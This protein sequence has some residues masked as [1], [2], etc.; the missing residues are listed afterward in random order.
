M[1]EYIAAGW[2]NDGSL[3]P[4][5]E[6]LVDDATGQH[7]FVDHTTQTTSWVDPRDIFIK[8]QSF[9]DCVGDELPYGWEQSV[10]AQVS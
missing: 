3:P 8:K 10:D 9:E 2:K 7:F 5:W 6:E 1:A 4:G